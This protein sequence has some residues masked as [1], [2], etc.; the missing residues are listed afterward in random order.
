M[1]K[2]PSDVKNVM[3]ILT[4]A[5]HKAY[6]VGGC[7]RDSIMGREPNDWDVTTSA[8]PDRI[9]E[10]FSSFRTVDTGIQ[11]GT[12][13]IVSGKTPVETT[14]FRVD[15][16]YKDN[17]HPESVSFTSDIKD[18]LARR[19]FTINAMAYNE[20]DGLIDPFGGADDIKNKIIRCVGDADTRFGE[21]ALRIMRA[22]RFSSVLGFSIEENTSQ[23]IL[24]N[25]NLLSGIA[26]ERISNEL[27]KLLCGENVFSVLEKYRSVIGVF[28]PE[29]KLEFDFPQYGKKHGYDVWMH[30]VH[31]VNNI[32]NDPI[33]R[34]TMLL[35][36]CGKVATHAIDENG[37]STFRNHAAVGG[38]IA[39]NILRRLKFSKNYISTVS[40]L[41]SVHDKEVP[42]TRED[43]KKYIRLL[44]EENYIRL[45]KIRR[46]DKSGLAKGYRDITDKLL[47]AYSTFDDVMNSNEP[48]SLPQLAVNGNDIKKY[49]NGNEI[50]NTLEY[51]LDIVTADPTKNTKE[52]LLELVKRKK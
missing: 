33:L 29:M 17:R 2:I 45:M 3:N 47:F 28:M 9:K 5:G 12:V 18:D 6:V 41:V 51:L 15:G 37:N 36:D 35:H 48:Y 10:L 50:G 39:E 52:Q 24:K 38:V 42:E 40:F 30:T 26:A 32:D 49:V 23:S 34:L 27:I 13:L 16:E 44:G 4:S 46:A 7:V 31:T 11:H 1:I 25:E 14:T 43:V 19:D 21:D 22:V 8:T 20:T